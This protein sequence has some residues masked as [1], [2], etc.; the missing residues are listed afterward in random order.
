[1]VALNFRGTAHG[2][3]SSV[4]GEDLSDLNHCEIATTQ[5]GK[6]GGLPL[7]FEHDRKRRVGTVLSSWEGVN[8]ELRVCGVVDDADVA[9]RVRDGSARGLSLGSGILQDAETGRKLSVVQEELSLCAEPRRPGCYVTHV[10]GVEV[11]GQA[12][13]SARIRRELG[14]RLKLR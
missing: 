1:M 7:C 6:N 10:D 14:A 12:Q 9:S 5:L 11:Y 8:G 13:N 3:A 4:S 2:A